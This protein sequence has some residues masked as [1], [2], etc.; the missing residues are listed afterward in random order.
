[1]AIHR[2][3]VGRV[4]AT[5]KNSHPFEV[6]SGTAPPHV[7]YDA[8]TGL[9]KEAKVAERVELPG[10]L[11]VESYGLYRSSDRA[12]PVPVTQPEPEPEK[13]LGT[14]P[15][16]LKDWRANFGLARSS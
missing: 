4:R 14:V 13:G 2:P 12:H 8:A 15:G 5:R 9:A 6:P 10:G 11:V 7:G 16:P 1:M 3:G